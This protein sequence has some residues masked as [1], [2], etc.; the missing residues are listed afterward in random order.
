MD[1]ELDTS[2]EPVDRDRVVNDPT[3][4]SEAEM[5][6]EIAAIETQ[7]HRATIE[8]RLAEAR[9]D[10]DRGFPSTT[11]V[12]GHQAK[13]G[14]RQ[15]DPTTAM[16]GALAVDRAAYLRDID[17]RKEEAQL[18]VPKIPTYKGESY[19]KLQEFT[20]A[21]EHMYETRPVTYRSVKDQVMLTKG[22]LQDSPRNAWYREYPT[23]IDHNY[24]WEEFKRFLL[25]DLSP[26]NIRSQDVFRDYKSI[27]QW[28]GETVDQLVDRI[29]MLEE[30]MPP[31]PE[32]T[33]VHTLLFALN[34]TMQETILKRQG[35]FDTRN[36]LQ[37]LAV[38]LEALE[39]KNTK[40]RERGGTDDVPYDKTKTR[41]RTH[42]HRVE[43]AEQRH[44]TRNNGRTPNTQRGAAPVSGS[45]AAAPGP[46]RQRVPKST[47]DLAHITCYNCEKTG[48]YS[49]KC[50]EPQKSG[51]GPAH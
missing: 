21:C 44:A 29:N 43:K 27:R 48:H 22:N 38:E 18:Y 15:V 39:A 42:N 17:T 30:Q 10:C 37:K 5:E 35:S 12:T 16:T 25:N 28:G 3:P 51:K 1:Y 8:R 46:R 2:G 9:S 23:G 32:A 19:L 4:A 40:R 36:E 41:G 45:N 34:L 7:R 49:N 31:H 47:K 20:R 6:A 50:P 14:N 11:T 24:T 26:S 33:R 13:A